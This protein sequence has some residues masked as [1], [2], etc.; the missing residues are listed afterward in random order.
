MF[1]LRL[2]VAN[3]L[4]VRRKNFRVN[5]F[6]YTQLEVCRQTRFHD[7]VET[8]FPLTLHSAYHINFVDD[9]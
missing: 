7:E 8:K 4:P 6:L 1:Q 5:R 3:S 9:Y 2:W